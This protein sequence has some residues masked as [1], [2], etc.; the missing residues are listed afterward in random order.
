LRLLIVTLSGKV[1]LLNRNIPALMF[2]VDV[3]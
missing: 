3:Q 1:V 2:L